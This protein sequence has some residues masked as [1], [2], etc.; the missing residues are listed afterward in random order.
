[1]PCACI[2]AWL[3]IQILELV[4]R[5]NPRTG[6]AYGSNA[7]AW[8]GYQFRTPFKTGEPSHT[9]LLLLSRC[10]CQLLK[11]PKSS[12]HSAEPRIHKMWP[13]RSSAVPLCAGKAREVTTIYEVVEDADG[14]VYALPDYQFTYGNTTAYKGPLT[15][16]CVP[17]SG[18]IPDSNVKVPWAQNNKFAPSEW[19]GRCSCA[20]HCAMHAALL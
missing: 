20:Q 3:Q 2:A 10:G 5:K 16:S 15:A 7:A 19:Q 18:S 4:P 8:W 9:L 12:M 17:K 13:R 1:M 6:K 11:Y 14:A